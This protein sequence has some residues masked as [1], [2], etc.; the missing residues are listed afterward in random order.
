MRLTTYDE[1]L[2]T[3]CNFFDGLIAPMK[4]RRTNRNVVYLML[5]AF[6]KG[7]ELINSVC[8][9]LSGRF[10]P[11]YCADS[12]L[13][14]SA[15]LVGTVRRPGSGS[16]LRI[17][18][19]NTDEYTAAV[20]PA[21]VYTYSYSAD[22]S[23]SFEV[24]DAVTLAGR[25][26]TTF[27]AMS[28]KIGSFPVTEQASIPVTSEQTVPSSLAFS[29]EDNE[30]LQGRSEESLPDFRERL[31]HSTDRQSG[32]IELE[33]E[34]KALPYLFD[35]RCVY[36]NSGS[37]ESVGDV[38]VPYSSMAVFAEGDMKNDIARIVS[39]HIICPT[40]ATQDSVAL[41]YE[42]DLFID[43]YQEVNVIPF[44]HTTYSLHITYVASE[45]YIN[46]AQKQ[47]EFSS[48]LKR[49]FN[50]PIH[51]DLI[52]ENDIYTFLNNLGVPGVSFLAVQITYGG[53]DVPYIEV[54][55]SEIAQ[56]GLVTYTRKEPA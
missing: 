55:K 22:V 19:T 14:S 10:D 24:A 34:L 37:N 4:I 33:D 25:D 42:N 30:Y 23:F 8:Y 27:T 32:I 31:R 12:D 9:A 44:K 46:P 52:S 28:D 29:C 43:G 15:A 5:K 38:T 13:D 39:E 53:L 50:V 40:V 47:A 56:I 7:L 21:G 45:L 17:I 48:A 35:A 41:R 11:R 2:T 36:N 1:F 18:V 16:G 51:K 6:A 3:L 54:P 49:H 20:L 26:Y